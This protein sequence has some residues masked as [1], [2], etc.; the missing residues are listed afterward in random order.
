MELKNKL[1]QQQPSYYEINNS[2]NNLELEEN[3]KKI[4][5][6]EENI[7]KMKEIMKEQYKILLGFH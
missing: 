4:N 2:I 1:Q 7:I 5:K 6:L 3:K